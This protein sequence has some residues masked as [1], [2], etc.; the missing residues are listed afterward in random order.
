MSISAGAGYNTQ[1]TFKEYQTYD[2]GKRDWLGIDD[3][4]RSMP[5]GLPSMVLLMTQTI[6]Q[7]VGQIL[8]LKI[9][10]ILQLELI[11]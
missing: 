7:N 11:I 5:V 6:G 8:I 3:G 1:S 2:G 4:K 10:L 9:L